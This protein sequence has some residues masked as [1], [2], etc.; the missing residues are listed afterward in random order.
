MFQS[1]KDWTDP[2]SL[3][4]LPLT[5]SAIRDIMRRDPLNMRGLL[6]GGRPERRHEIT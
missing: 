6:K 1:E 3:A 2:A 4:K 5:D